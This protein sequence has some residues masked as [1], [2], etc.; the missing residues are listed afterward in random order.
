MTLCFVIDPVAPQDEENE[1]T[2]PP[3]PIPSPA[4]AIR[5]KRAAS[6]TLRMKGRD[7]LGPNRGQEVSHIKP[8]DGHVLRVRW[9]AHGQSGWGWGW[10]GVGD[11]APIFRPELGLEQ[12]NPQPSSFSPPVHPS[13][14]LNLD[15][16]T[17]TPSQ[18]PPTSHP[19][20]SSLRPV[21]ASPR[22]KQQPPHYGPAQQPGASGRGNGGASEES[23]LEIIMVDEEE[24]AG[25]W[26]GGEGLQGAG[27]DG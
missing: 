11:A 19:G 20:S 22:V 18:L 27:M 23:D 1:V 7:R 15:S 25:G 2:A 3:K 17:P 10:G 4:P 6:A 9:P 14:C 16:P 12:R 21:S 24:E 26:D 8:D 13:P 5:P